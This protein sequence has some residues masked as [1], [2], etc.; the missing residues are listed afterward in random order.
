M[1]REEQHHMNLTM[2]CLLGMVMIVGLVA[3]VLDSGIASGQMVGSSTEIN[4]DQVL[5]CVNACA[6]NNAVASCVESCLA[7]ESPP[8]E[9]H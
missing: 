2:L 1:N 6:D 9:N 3:L 8:A 7:E 4:H 5:R